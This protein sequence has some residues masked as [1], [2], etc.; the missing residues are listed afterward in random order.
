MSTRIAGS[1]QRWKS[2][3]LAIGERT[4]DGMKRPIRACSRNVDGRSSPKLHRR[5]D[6]RSG[7]TST[8]AS[9]SS[10]IIT[11]NDVRVW[12]RQIPLRVVVAMVCKGS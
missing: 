6:A 8:V 7:V 1:E 9:M 5:V 12:V 11:V 10:R 4:C 3:A 2:T